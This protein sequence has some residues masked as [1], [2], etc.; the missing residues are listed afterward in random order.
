[1]S[2]HHKILHASC[3]YEYFC[4]TKFQNFWILLLF[5]SEFTVHRRTFHVG[6]KPLEALNLSGFRSWGTKFWQFWSWGTKNILILVV[7]LEN[8]SPTLLHVR[9]REMYIKMNCHF[10]HLIAIIRIL[11]RWIKHEDLGCCCFS[12][13]HLLSGKPVSFWVLLSYF[14]LYLKFPYLPGLRERK[15]E[16][17]E[18]EEGPFRLG[19]RNSVGFS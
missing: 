15:S 17:R 12:R 1:M 18:D 4:P 19:I 16:K 2:K 8:N 10:F 5:V 6:Q 7:Q 11:S 3:T 13:T 14:S 9:E